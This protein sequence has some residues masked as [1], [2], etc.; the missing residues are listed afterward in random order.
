MF[1]D[2]HYKGHTSDGKYMQWNMTMIKV[3]SVMMIIG[4]IPGFATTGLLLSAVAVSKTFFDFAERKIIMVS[5]FQG[6][7]AVVGLKVY[8]ESIFQVY[9]HTLTY[10]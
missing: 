8:M 10:I 9:K 2:F 5:I 7:S 6:T 4:S 3:L 1:H